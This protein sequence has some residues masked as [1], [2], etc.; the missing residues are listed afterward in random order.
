[1]LPIIG[2]AVTKTKLVTILIGSM[3]TLLPVVA[4]AQT[5]FVTSNYRPGGKDLLSG[6]G[7]VNL[8]VSILEVSVPDGTYVINAKT[9]IIN[10]DDDAQSGNCKLWVLVGG[11]GPPTGKLFVIDQTEFRTD[12]R[13]GGNQQAI[14]L[15]AVF[16][17]LASPPG[18]VITTS[19][20]GVECRA[21]NGVAVDSVLT[22]VRIGGP[23][24]TLPPGGYE[25][26]PPPQQF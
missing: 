2:R 9:S 11:L 15:Q 1:V 13:D 26:P 24:M 4:R 19:L 5:A 6:P 20:I 10:G 22:A 25:V 17:I 18:P 21:Y 8:G 7:P 12:H 16:T 23:I 3:L 14:A